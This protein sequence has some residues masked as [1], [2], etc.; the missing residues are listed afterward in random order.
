M[1]EHP[2]RSSRGGPA[3]KLLAVMLDTPDLVHVVQSLEPQLLAR[4]I[5]QVGLED[6][7]EIVALV[8][9]EQLEGVFDQDLWRSEKPG[10]DETFDA[11][12]FVL[13]LSVLLESG[14]E[15]AARKL[16]ELDQDLVAL[17]LCKQ[18]LVLDLERLDAAIAEPGIGAG[19]LIEKV[20]ESS[21]TQELDDYLLVA[22]RDEGFDTLIQLLTTLDR[23]QHDFV[24][25]LLAQC[26]QITSELVDDS[27]GLYD[28][29]TSEESLAEDVAGARSDRREQH[30][31]VAASDARSFLALARMRTPDESLHETEPDPITRAYFRNLGSATRDVAGA[32]RAAEPAARDASL[33]KLQT[34][35]EEAGVVAPARAAPLLTAGEERSSGKKRSLIERVLERSSAGDPRVHAERLEELAYLSNVLL[36]GCAHRGRSL[37]PVE[38]AR[39][40][41]AVCEVGLERI[42]A[43]IAG[44]RGA[45]ARA[46]AAWARHSAVKAFR[47]GWHLLHAEL[48]RE[49]DRTWDEILD[50]L[51]AP[52]RGS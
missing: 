36:A 12:R 25:R 35:L 24:T 3:G 28:A 49:P 16:L 2:V 6:A 37:R 40:A 34:A 41:M 21:L 50:R 45:D 32:P 31:Y 26:C 4:V 10:E 11:D 27:G 48:E 42:G 30:G 5:E 7:G 51:L 39:L 33:S 52:A 8:T 22:R 15:F 19:V 29:L 47:I 14:E 38:A 18:L 20:L 44:K 17:A 43:S 1:T 9:N 13:W 23:D 46:S